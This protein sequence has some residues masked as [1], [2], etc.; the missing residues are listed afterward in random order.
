MTE[1]RR[2]RLLAGVL[3]GV[4]QL[5]EGR[6]GAGLFAL[7]A[8]ALGLWTLLVRWERVSGLPY[9][10]PGEWVALAALVAAILGPWLWSVRGGGCAPP[11]AGT[12][13][14]P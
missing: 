14:G 7:V 13:S 1:T 4:P 5:L 11:S 2:G 6:W 3:P 8:W 9:E 12:A 10:S